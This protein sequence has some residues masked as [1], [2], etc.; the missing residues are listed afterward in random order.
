MRATHHKHQNYIL[1]IRKTHNRKQSPLRSVTGLKPLKGL[2]L[3]KL[4]FLK[5][6]FTY[7]NMQLY[8]LEKHS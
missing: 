7:A 8:C 6:L 4:T 2:L 3:W 1:E 5:L